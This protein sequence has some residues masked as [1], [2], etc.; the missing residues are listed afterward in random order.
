M[1]VGNT[2]FSKYNCSIRIKIFFVLVQV[3]VT[4][5]QTNEAVSQTVLRMYWLDAHED[6]V[7]HPGREGAGRSN[8]PE[9]GEGT[10]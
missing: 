2:C 10:Y 4:D 6:P 8:K 3:E 5:P 9:E 1:R 7:K